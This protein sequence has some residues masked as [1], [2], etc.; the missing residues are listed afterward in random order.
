MPTI[1]NELQALEISMLLWKD[2]SEKAVFKRDS[3]YFYLVENSISECSLCQAFRSNSCTDC[4][5]NSPKLCQDGAGEAY[6]DWAHFYDEKSYA[7]AIILHKAIEKRYEE[8][9]NQ[10][11]DYPE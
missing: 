7:P 1:D 4:C 5:L 10:K 2:L 9:T 8:L 11:P 6:S 3:K